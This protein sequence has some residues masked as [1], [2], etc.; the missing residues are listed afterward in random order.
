MRKLLPTAVAV[1][2]TTLWVAPAEAKNST[3]C[4]KA[5]GLRMSVIKKHGKRAPGRNICR[6]GVRV[7]SGVKSATTRQ[8]ARYVRALR[9]LNAPRPYLTTTAGSPARPPAGT[10][11]ARHAP[12]GLAA[13]IVQRESSGNPNAVNGEHTGIGQWTQEAWTRHGGTR[14]AATPLGATYQQQLVVLSSG[15]ARYGC[16]D[17][18]P[19][20]GCG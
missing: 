15:L 14:Y 5:H 10:L 6:Q 2:T 13:C 3:L 1:L 20:D 16:R 19:F 17:W 9:S 18:C 12:S 11:T 8:K 4:Y 7:D